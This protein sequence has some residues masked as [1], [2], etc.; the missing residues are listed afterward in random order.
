MRKPYEEHMDN[1]AI[2]RDPGKSLFHKD[3]IKSVG[4]MAGTFALAHDSTNAPRLS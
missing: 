1:I 2:F 4:D 3:I